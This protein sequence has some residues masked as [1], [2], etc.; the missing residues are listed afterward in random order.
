MK[1][2]LE[3]MLEA[4][5]EDMGLVLV[6]LEQGPGFL[7]VFV[8]GD[9]GVSVEECAALSRRV[10]KAIEDHG[11]IPGPFVL[12]V[13]SPGLDRVLKTPRE[14]AW[15][16][17]KRVKAITKDGRVR[18]GRLDASSDSEINLDGEVL[19]IS[20]LSRLVLAETDK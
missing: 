11:L 7:R 13:S 5:A 2:T 14:R 15:A 6:A 12:E 10:S 19:S 8:D 3:K 18:V 20:E 16:V 9:H 4:L 1:E 17:G